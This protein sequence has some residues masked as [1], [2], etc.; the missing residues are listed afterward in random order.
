MFDAR[1]RRSIEKILILHLNFVLLYFVLH[2][3]LVT[4]V[5][6]LLRDFGFGLVEAQFVVTLYLYN[7]Q[8]IWNANGVRN[9]A[10]FERVQC[11]LKIDW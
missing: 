6:Q 9:L 8:S 1:R 4:F 10:R 7:Q 5:L 2:G 3:S 11:C